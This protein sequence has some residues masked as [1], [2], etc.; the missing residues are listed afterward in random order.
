MGAEYEREKKTAQSGE[1]VGA[2]FEKSRRDFLKKSARLFEKECAVDFYRLHE[3]S[4]Y[5]PVSA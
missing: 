3:V 4:I 1:K 5:I 2:V